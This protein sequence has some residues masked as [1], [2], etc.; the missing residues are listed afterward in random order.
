V[1]DSNPATGFNQ[2]GGLANSQF[3]RLAF[4]INELRSG[5]MPYFG[6]KCPCLVA[7]V[8]PLCNQFW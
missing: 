2:Y 1:M 4:G 6:A 7:F 3:R 5:Q 8:Q